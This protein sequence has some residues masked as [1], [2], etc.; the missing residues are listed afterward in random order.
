MTKKL[1]DYI[2][3]GGLADAQFVDQIGE[4][5]PCLAFEVAAEW[6]G[7]MSAQATCPRTSRM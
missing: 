3:A 1:W 7:P 5:P 2:K 4:C 6:R